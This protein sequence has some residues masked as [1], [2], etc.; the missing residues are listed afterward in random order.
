MQGQQPCPPTGVSPFLDRK[1]WIHSD[2]RLAA[3]AQIRWKKIPQRQS[4]A[5]LLYTRVKERERERER[6]RVCV[7]VC[8]CMCACVCIWH[9]IPISLHPSH[10]LCLPPF[11]RRHQSFGTIEDSLARVDGRAMVTQ[12]RVPL[13]RHSLVDVL[14]AKVFLPLVALQRLAV[15]VIPKQPHTRRL[16]PKQQHTQMSK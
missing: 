13:K 3:G 12:V 8:V 6:E 5:R 10:A 14:G 7:C 2:W 9:F 4:R 16:R 15:R 11:S 1:A